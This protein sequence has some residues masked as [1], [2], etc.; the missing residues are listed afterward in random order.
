MCPHTS[1]ETFVL[2][3]ARPTTPPSSKKTAA[4][5]SVPP[6]LP[7]TPPPPTNATTNATTGNFALLPLRTRTRG[8]AY[9]LP[10]LP[11]DTSDL[12]LD[13]A[14]ESYDILDESLSLFRANTLFRN[15]E[16]KGPADR[17]LIY[18]ILYISDLLSRIAAKPTLSQREAEKLVQAAALEQF[19]LPGEPGFP[20]NAQFQGARD[21][22]E[23]ETL[24]GYIGQVRQELGARL[25][26]R[27]YADGTGRPS[28]WWL[29]FAKRKFMGKS[30]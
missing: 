12:N 4:S 15:F 27:L 13:P 18:S 7:S 23:A 6:S 28:K 8:P 22:Q 17:V 26:G 14:H 5:T 20:L 16:I 19:A 9:V 1:L 30:L 2:T 11:A 25:V 3:R 10:S 21:R 24:R 29:S